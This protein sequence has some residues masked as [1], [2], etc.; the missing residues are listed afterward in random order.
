MATERFSVP[1]VPSHPGGPEYR[2]L[3]E[4]VRRIGESHGFQ[5]IEPQDPNG[6]VAV[7]VILDWDGWR[8]ACQIS[9]TLNIEQEIRN[10]RKILDSGF[11]AVAIVSPEKR[12]NGKLRKS[13]AKDFS[14]DEAA[15]VR[16]LAPEELPEYLK[17]LKTP[18]DHVDIVNGYKVKVRYVVTDPADQERRR[19]EIARIIARSLLRMKK[20]SGKT[21]PS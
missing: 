16:V 11:D 19:R 15:R 14:Q 2:Y 10:A 8:L 18:V 4:I 17:E 9:M 13:I 5:F 20:E 21:P 7:D 1:V 6:Q 3:Q 12:Q